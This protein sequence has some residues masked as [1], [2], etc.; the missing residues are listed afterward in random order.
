MQMITA[1]MLVHDV[2]RQWPQTMKVF[3]HY[4]LDLCCGGMHSLE[5]VA[6]KHSL[7]LNRILTELNSAVEETTHAG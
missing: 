1:S 5:F 4:N 6:N 2:A 3:A 7:D